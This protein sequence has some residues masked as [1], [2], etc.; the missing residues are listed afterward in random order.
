ME[1]YHNIDVSKL[2]NEINNKNC[3]P[4]ILEGKDK[5]YEKLNDRE[6]E[7]L[8]YYLFKK[9]MVGETKKYD[10]IDLMQGVGEKGRDCVL[11]KEGQVKGIIQC[12]HTEKNNNRMDKPSALKEI[13]K[14]ALNC[15]KDK[16]MIPSDII[17]DYHFVHSFAFSQPAQC[18]LNNFYTEVTRD[19]DKLKEITNA[20]INKN[21][22]LKDLKYECIH[23]ELLVILK[24]LN[25]IKYEK[26]DIDLLMAN[27]NKILSIFFKVQKV[28]IKEPSL[29]RQY[30]SIEPDKDA[31]KNIYSNKVFI[32]KLKEI[33][34]KMPDVIQAI[35]NYWS[36]LETLELLCTIEYF[37]EEEIE[38]YQKDL[39]FRYINQYKKDCE[40][41]SDK[42]TPKGIKSESRKFYWEVMN[43]NPIKIIGLLDN[44]PFFQNG[45]YQDLA[46]GDD[47][48]TW[49]LKYVDEEAEYEDIDNFL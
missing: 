16:T 21:S 44:R 7:V 11:Y 23:D 4:V 27:Q 3:K 13:V 26:Q 28:I 41:I 25:I 1:H 19:G 43:Q 33:G 39:I 31:V 46:N 29:P 22:K 49:M 47:I 20:V 18:M 45:M 38:T 8:S 5:P 30:E 48:Q 32:H 10:Y 6:F 35:K 34:I 24:R 14:F 12:K 2:I 9:N 17:I 42:D 40:N 36:A 37:D 15:I